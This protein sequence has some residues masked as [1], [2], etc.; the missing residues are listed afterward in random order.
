VINIITRRASDTHGALVSVA[1]G[2]ITHGSVGFR[3]GGGN[4]HNLNYRLYGKG[5]NR[6][7]EFL[8][9]QRQFD[10]WRM[11]QA[12]FRTDWALTQIVTL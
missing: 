10:D 12:G 3:Y 2:N 1:G 11:G 4:D 7:H 9:G 8:S 5:F 6:G